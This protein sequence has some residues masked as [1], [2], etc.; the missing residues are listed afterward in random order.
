MRRPTVDPD[1]TIQALLAADDQRA[2]T[3]I[4]DRHASGL[5]AYA[6]ALVGAAGAE[7]VV[8][9]L[10]AAIAHHRQA[11]ARA[12]RLPAY[13]VSMVRNLATAWRQR[14]RPRA[15]ALPENLVAPTLEG[16]DGETREVLRLAIASLPEVQREVVALHAWQGMG[17][18]EIA[19]VLDISLSTA[20]ER[21]QSALTTLRRRLQET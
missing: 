18:A 9:E 4:Y 21:W 6:C 7:E 13:L 5:H 11:V 2:L 16:F 10:F 1:R 20:G 14:H 15:V 3:L 12:D 8:Q 17:F 19:I